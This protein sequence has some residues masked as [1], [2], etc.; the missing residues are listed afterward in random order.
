MKLNQGT[1]AELPTYPRTVCD[2]FP[3]L[4]VVHAF[5]LIV[6]YDPTLLSSYLNEIVDI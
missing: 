2:L 6:A 4:P 1:G 3:S 5:A